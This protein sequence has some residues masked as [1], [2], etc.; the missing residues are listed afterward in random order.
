MRDYKYIIVG[1]GA[2]AASAAEAIRRR[3]PGGSLGIFTR[4]WAPP[5]QRPPLSKEFL[6]NRAPLADALMLPAH[7]Y[8]EN[9]VD[10]HIGVPVDRLDPEK[11]QVQ[12]AAGSIG[13]ERLLLAT[14]AIPRTLDVPGVGL[15]SVYV[16]RTYLDAE[17]LR[18]VRSSA[19]R[20]VLIGSGFIG[21]EVAAS[22]RSGGCDVTIVTVDTALYERF[23]PD[24]SGYAQSLFNRHGVQTFLATS[25]RSIDGDS[26]VAGVTLADGRLLEANAVVIGIGAL[27]ETT[28]A[29][30]AAL[31]IHDGIVVDDHLRTSAE[32]VFAAGD[33]ARFPGVDGR[34]VRVEHFDHAQASG[35][36][37][38]A[39]MARANEPY[40]Y[41]PF[42]WS[43]VFELNFEFIGDPGGNARIVSG[44]IESGS[45][46]VE[47]RDVDTLIGV[48]LA[49][50]SAE[51]RDAYREQLLTHS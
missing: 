5:Y 2:S 38:G 49:R 23:G 36:A 37:A 7:W 34:L 19:R 18:G 46:V 50:R 27:P 31:Q 13:Y 3:D 26:R 24:V 43:D 48:L 16:L 41:V 15:E 25:V 30:A 6:Q 39:N 8:A 21:M 1:G 20:V 35:A 33:V 42:F 28:L 14:G 11:R 47:Y 4:E 9:G 44:T 40:R 32:G 45:F 10:L 17:Q 51:E 22:L 29:E 12:T